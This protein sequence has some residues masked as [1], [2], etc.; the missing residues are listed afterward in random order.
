MKSF[1]RCTLLRCNLVTEEGSLARRGRGAVETAE[2]GRGLR[3]RRGSRRG[4]GRAAEERRAG[5]GSRA[6][7]GVTEAWRSGMRGA[8]TGRAG[9]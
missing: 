2:R 8:G 7:G 3:G 4:A 1:L 5:A 6:G 9:R